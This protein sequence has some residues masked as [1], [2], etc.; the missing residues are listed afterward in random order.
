MTLISEQ[1]DGYTYK[2]HPAYRRNWQPCWGWVILKNGS[3]VAEGLS[4]TLDEAK[5]TVKRRIE[6][7]KECP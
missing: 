4:A 6:I 3:E 1:I 5:D 7:E 2:I